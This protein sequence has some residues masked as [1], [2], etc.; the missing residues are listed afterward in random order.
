MA[1]I[2]SGHTEVSSLS[3]E[4]EGSLYGNGAIDENGKS[5]NC[6]SD[7]FCVMMMQIDEKVA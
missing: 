3:R 6:G 2:S 7:L 5:N 1:T 4:N